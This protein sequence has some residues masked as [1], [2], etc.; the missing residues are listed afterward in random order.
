MSVTLQYFAALPLQQVRPLTFFVLL[1][2][3]NSIAVQIQSSI[4]RQTFTLSV[5]I[6][7]TVI[8]IIGY[9]NFHRKLNLY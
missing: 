5:T 2:M 7:H 6:S 9:Y 1:Y 3:F 4:T 8:T